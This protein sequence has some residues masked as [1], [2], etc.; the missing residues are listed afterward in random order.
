MLS[1]DLNSLSQRT[2][3]SASKLQFCID[4]VVTDR[5]WMISEAPV[6]RQGPLDFIAAV[7]VT[8]SAL[9]IDG[10]CSPM[11]VHTFM[12]AIAFQQRPRRNPL[13]LPL[14]SDAITGTERAIVHIADGTHVRWLIG[15]QDS[16]WHRFTPNKRSEPDHEP[17]VVVALN[18]GR[19]RDLIRT[20]G[21]A[22]PAS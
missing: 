10:G 16:R 11:A 12:R 4:N 6:N 20:D 18:I 5:D 2:G 19:V 8:C 1:F 3:I 14:I 15:I 9:L 22:N 17:T 7:H 21:P 13:N